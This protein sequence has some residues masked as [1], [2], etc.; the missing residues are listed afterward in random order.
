MRQRFMKNAVFGE[1]PALDP[2][3][4]RN[5]RS[6]LRLAHANY[7]LVLGNSAPMPSFIVSNSR[8]Q[9]SIESSR[10]MTMVISV[11]RSPPLTSPCGQHF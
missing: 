3:R 11:H 7:E 10:I 8:Q 2:K 9:Q 6:G 1:Q 5:Y 4:K